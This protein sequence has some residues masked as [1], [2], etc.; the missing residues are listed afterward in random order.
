MLI[1]RV[2]NRKSLKKPDMSHLKRPS[3][4]DPSH[5]LGTVL[6]TGLSK[7]FIDMNMNDVED[8]GSLDDDNFYVKNDNEKDWD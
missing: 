7:R 5:P 8:L 2:S 4:T 1:C 6:R 3:Y